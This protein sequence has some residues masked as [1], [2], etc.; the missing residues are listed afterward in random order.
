MNT[1]NLDRKYREFIELL[2]IKTEKKDL[3]DAHKSLMEEVLNIIDALRE[4]KA[5]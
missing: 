2:T 5:D 3:V 4:E 1:E